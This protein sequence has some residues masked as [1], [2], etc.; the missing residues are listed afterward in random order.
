MGW[1]GGGEGFN[2]K[3]LEEAWQGIGVPPGFP[4]GLR[5]PRAS[6]FHTLYVDMDVLTASAGRAEHAVSLLVHGMAPATYPHIRLLPGGSDSSPGQHSKGSLPES[7]TLS[8]G[9]EGN[10]QEA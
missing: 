6:P 8:P 9:P 7:Q 4:P 10:T 3:Q 2:L 5:G 1:A